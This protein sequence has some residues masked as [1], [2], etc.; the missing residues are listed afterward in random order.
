MP[1]FKLI[2][3][4]LNIISPFRLSVFNEIVQI[5]IK[6]RIVQPSKEAEEVM[7]QCF[8]KLQARVV[9]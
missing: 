3:T 9:I 6:Q 8:I 2:H 7:L 4:A 5:I 1:D